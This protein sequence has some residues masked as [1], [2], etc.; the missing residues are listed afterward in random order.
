MRRGWPALAESDVDGWLVRMSGGVTQ[1]ANSVVPWADPPRVDAALSKVERL[2]AS[3]GLPAVF[4]LGP[5]ARPGD[6]NERLAARGYRYGSPTLVLVADTSTALANLPESAPGPVTISDEPA[7]AWMDLWWRVDGRG[8][9]KARSVAR[10]I[11][12]RGPARYAA[13]HDADKEPL[14]VARLA[15]VDNWGGLYCLAVHPAARRRGLA[16]AATRALVADAAGKGVR[17]LWLQ[18]RKENEAARALYARA[19]F[20]QVADYHYR[21][22]PPTPVR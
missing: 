1:R 15:L 21:T 18:V 4:Q 3:H 12:T 17:R 9:A 20:S 2:Y 16:A 11:L 7:E 5:T 6:L 14:A 19:G 10:R 22:Q 13:V 8:D